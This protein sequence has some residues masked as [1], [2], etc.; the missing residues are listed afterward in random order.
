MM[1]G[2]DHEGETS[3]PRLPGSHR[4]QRLRIVVGASCQHGAGK[5]LSV[6]A[7]ASLGASYRAAKCRRET[8]FPH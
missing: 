1:P 6:F 7:A 2:N 8:P 3:C 4:S 5:H